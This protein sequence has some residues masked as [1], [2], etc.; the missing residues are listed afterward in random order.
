GLITGIDFA[1]G[2]W[3]FR[4][5]RNWFRPV[6]ISDLRLAAKKDLT[7]AILRPFILAATFALSFGITAPLHFVDNYVV[8]WF[9]V[10]FAFGSLDTEWPLYFT[11]I[12]WLALVRRDL[13]IRLTRFLECCRTA[14]I[15]RVI[16]QEYQIHDVGLLGWLQSGG[17]VT[18][19]RR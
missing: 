4:W 15:L 6:L 11:A 19:C 7:G 13:P 14:G 2:A 18:I 17:T 12:L 3:L 5:S 16:G 10:G 8:S 1:L 9:V